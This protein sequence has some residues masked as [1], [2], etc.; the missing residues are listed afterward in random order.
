MG[1][2]Q[3]LFLSRALRRGQL[4]VLVILSTQN[5][6]ILKT[7]A[8]LVAIVLVALVKLILPMARILVALNQLVGDVQVIP[9]NTGKMPRIL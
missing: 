5:H 7:A 8:R 6:V 3:D 2:I 4:L 9:M 1:P